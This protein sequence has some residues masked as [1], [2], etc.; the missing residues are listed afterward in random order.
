M[1]TL[2]IALTLF[3]TLQNSEIISDKNSV[4]TDRTSKLNIFSPDAVGYGETVLTVSAENDSRHREKLNLIRPDPSPFTETVKTVSQKNESSPSTTDIDHSW[5]QNALEELEKNEYNITYNENLGTYQSPNRANN[6]RFVYHKD[7]FT[8]KTRSFDSPQRHEDTKENDLNK[9]EVKKSD[10]WSIDFKLKGYS[11]HIDSYQEHAVMTNISGNLSVA[12]NKASVEDEKLRIDYTNDKAGM[13][14]DFIIKKKPEGEGKLRMNIT[15]D[16]KLKMIV[17]ADA[18]MFKDKNGIDKMKYSALKCWDANGKELRAYFEKNDQFQIT[19]DKL[20]I[21]NKIQ[22]SEEKNICNL[23]FD[24]SNSFSIVV[25]DE[26]AVYPIT[27]DPLSTSPD[28]TMEG[29]QEHQYFGYSVAT[30]G[31]VNGDGYSD[32]IV[33]SIGYDNGESNEGGAFVYYG[34]ASGLPLLYNWSE[35]GNL[36]NASFGNCVATAGDVN[37]DG[38][39]DVLI[40]ANSYDSDSI[41]G[42]V[43]AY[44]GSFSGL[45]VGGADWTA[46]IN[47]Q[48][49]NFGGSVS[50]AGDVNGDGYSDILISAKDFSNVEIHEGAVFVYHGSPAGL[51]N[52]LSWSVQGAQANLLLGYSTSA[53]GDVN[54]DGYSDVIFSSIEYDNGK[55]KVF[56]YHGSSQGLSDT[57]NWS[58]ESSQIESFFGSSVSTAGDINGDGFSDIIVGA[59][60]YRNNKIDAGITGEGAAF[61]FL[62]SA[63]GLSI[64][65]DWTGEGEEEGS[66]YGHSVSTA[67]DVN[68]DGY[69]DVIIGANRYGNEEG[70]A[71]VYQGSAN[72]LSDSANW[73]TENNQ[74]ISSYGYSVST[75]GDINGDGYSDVLVGAWRFDAVTSNEGKVYLFNGSP[76]GLSDSDNWFTESDQE[77][78][79]FG[80]SVSTAG[81][82]NGDGYSDVIIGAEEYDDGEQNEG[83]AFVYLGSS[84]GLSVFHDWA[85]EGNQAEANYG[86]SVSTAGD[87]NGDGYADVIVGAVSYNNSE[88]FEGIAFLYLG[89]ASGLSDTA[90]WSAEGNQQNTSFGSAVSTAGDVNGDGFSD[91]IVGGANYD[92]SKGKTFVFH[93]STQGLSDS[94]DWTY[95]SVQGYSYFGG[96]VST[97]GDVNGDGYSD[98]IIGARNYRNN[99]LDGGPIGEG[100]AFVFYGSASGLSNAPDWTKEGDQNSSKFGNS[101]STAGDVNGDGFSDVMVSADNYNNGETGEGKVFVYYGSQ[102]GISNIE[103]WS[104]EGNLAFSNFG[105]SVSTAGDVNGDGYSDIIIG[106]QSFNAGEIEEGKAFVYHG[107][108]SGLSLTPDWTAESNLINANFGN[109]VFTAGDVN[110]DGYSDVIVG[111]L[112]Y[113][114]GQIN[115]G[116]AFVYYGNE[117]TGMR[118]TVRQYKPGTS[119]IV[120]SGGFTGTDG[121]VRFNI[122]GKSPFG[123]ADG[124]IVYEYKENSVPFSGTNITNSTLSSGSGNFTDLGTSI[125]GTELNKDAAGL[126]SDKEYKWRARV[127]YS[128]VNNPYQKFGPWKYYNNYVPTP[129]GNFKASDGNSPTIQLDLTMF[130]EAFYDANTNAMIGDTVTVYLRNYLSPYEVLDS[131]KEFV[132]SS[133]QALYE[134]YNASKFSAYY[135]HL[136][137]RNSIETWNNVPQLFFPGITP[138][139]FS[140][141]SSKAYGSNEIQI[142]L[143]PIR[144]GIYSGDVNQDGTVD[145]TDGSLIDNDAFNFVSGYVPTDVNGDGIVDLAD[146][147]FTDNNGFNFVSKITP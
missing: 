38:Y 108:S 12:G 68:G 121:Q 2:L 70:R 106:A 53:A 102:T 64:A 43:F 26:A 39:S 27:I 40:G 76:S 114:D 66:S 74:A 125:S 4:Y 56:V 15:A 83:S 14:Q 58:Y 96:S 25:N 134:F 71:Y 115:E 137:H 112:G 8:A 100:V 93:G 24:I 81:D 140:Q 36:A 126:L 32:V 101:V 111:A 55:G 82:V 86:Y 51:S 105:S 118:T 62:G 142:D 30:A 69:S 110:G 42:K 109:S 127:Q 116:A 84:S 63:S 144:F 10:E 28:W 130:I 6:I 147:V 79:Y 94:S 33:G 45:S 17:G 119:N 21:K 133:G 98:V 129:L 22:K 104:A 122:F 48:F 99:N 67:V 145:L 7:G 87:V 89:S 143:S 77:D 59:N 9:K 44:Y 95:E 41:G 141:N 138:Y 46:V 5:Y 146:A 23:K 107:S 73:I 113:N 124:K 19:N 11:K 103:D 50:T 34:S 54:G 85:G 131:A 29:K 75:A 65:P 132:N 47:Q 120:Y 78:A 90:N 52:S 3:P 91:V 57:L 139:D 61:V 72:G 97:A 117:G 136:K 1:I 20:Q 37:G 80:C 18:L 13:R 135:I 128:L 49:V 35:E 123:R 88:S 92:E 16:T 31:D 60:N